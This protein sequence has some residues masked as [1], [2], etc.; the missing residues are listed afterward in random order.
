[1]ALPMSNVTG[2]IPLALSRI[3]D[4][5]GDEARETSLRVLAHTL[6]EIPVP[7]GDDAIGS[8]PDGGSHHT[9][10]AVDIIGGAFERITSLSQGFEDRACRIRAFADACAAI[11]V[12]LLPLS[13]RRDLLDRALDLALSSADVAERIAAATAAL[14]AR[15][16]V[17]ALERT[18]EV[19]VDLARAA[20]AIPDDEARERALL[21]VASSLAK[22]GETGR[23]LAAVESLPISGRRALALAR[24]AFA[25]ERE[26]LG[27]EAAALLSQALLEVREARSSA[28]RSQA[29]RT[30]LD[31]AV[32]TG[33]HLG[34]HGALTLALDVADMMPDVAAQKGAIL[35]AVLALPETVFEEEA[36]TEA[37]QRI[38][39][40]IGRVDDLELR[41]GLYGRFAV[42]LVALG[43]IDACV[44]TLRTIAD[45]TAWLRATGA[46]GPGVALPIALPVLEILGVL[47]GVDFAPQDLQRF[48]EAALDLLATLDDHQGVAAL[49]GE[50]TRFFASPALAYAARVALLD[51]ALAA[52]Q[53]IELD[54]PRVEVVAHIADALSIAGAT[55]RGD[56]LF[57]GLAAGVG[58]RRARDVRLTRAVVLVRLGRT[59]DA[60]A[61]LAAAAAAAVPTFEAFQF[62]ASRSGTS[63]PRPSAHVVEE[64]AMTFARCGFLADMLAELARVEPAR[65]A[66]ARAQLADSLVE[67]TYLDPHLREIGLSFLLEPTEGPVRDAIACLLDQVR[68]LEGLGE[69]E[70]ILAR[71][72]ARTSAMEDRRTAG[73]YERQLVDALIE[74]IRAMPHEPRAPAR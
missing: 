2:L 22:C 15:V 25:L 58:P 7:L 34:F 62:D 72:F 5:R 57:A 51:R 50:M 74:R 1:M 68:V 14:D 47:T 67:A 10:G 3:A 17:R 53:A 56:A 9:S 35:G 24:V 45:L 65:Q 21:Q 54:A 49:L 30:I 8:S 20:A 13:R 39:D 26:G 42:S 46:E 71:A 73:L 19:L 29:L 36:L 18:E 64:I 55:E 69:V 6:N 23:A 11:A 60:R 38:A 32:Q 31:H 59:A 37:L 44:A 33:I 63:A 66:E 27:A 40:S 52:A 41:V 61:E 48:A 12:S 43:E 70:E 4:L 16:D 28:E